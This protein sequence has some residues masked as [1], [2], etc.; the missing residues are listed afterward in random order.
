MTPIDVV[1]L[2]LVS[3]LAL[4]SIGVPRALFWLAVI[5]VSYFVSGFYWRTGMVG[6]ELVAG[7]CDAAVV[8]LLV[9]LA[10]YRWEMWVALV[11]LVSLLVNIT[12][13]TSNLVGGG[14]IPHEAYAI[15]LEALNAIALFTIGG[16]AAFQRK[17]RTSGSAF[18]P[19]LS[20]FGFARPVG[21]SRR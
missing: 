17:G 11:F 16:V 13:L 10:A 2:G 18:R 19:W 12:F 1:F 7:L 8:A 15:T 20:V 4:V 3:G 21:R 14:L 9:L 5:T 6:G